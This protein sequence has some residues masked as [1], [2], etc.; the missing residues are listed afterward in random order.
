MYLLVS[1]ATQWLRDTKLP[2]SHSRALIRE[3]ARIGPQVPDLGLADYREVI[4]TIFET[5][6]LW[7]ANQAAMGEHWVPQ[8]FLALAG[9]ALTF[10]GRDIP[11]W[12]P[13]RR[14]T[15]CSISRP[16]LGKSI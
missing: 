6:R 1:L 2:S 12:S 5:G 3:L 9:A 7:A 13:P 10:I 8:S 16:W 14:T 11:G 15:G 4:D